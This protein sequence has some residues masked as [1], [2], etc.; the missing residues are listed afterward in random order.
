MNDE[1]VKSALAEEIGES[2]NSPSKDDLVS[3][4]T[5]QQQLCLFLSSRE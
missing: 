2:R 5:L 3:S 4:S 1:S